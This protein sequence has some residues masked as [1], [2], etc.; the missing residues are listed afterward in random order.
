MN[1]I[2]FPII[3]LFFMHFNPG[4]ANAQSSSS[5]I[6]YTEYIQTYKDIAIRKMNEYKIPASITLAQGLLESGSG[7][8]ALSVEANNHFGIKCHKEW[9]GM[10]YTMDDD[11][12]NECFRKYANPEESYNDHSLFLTTRPRYASLFE[13]DIKDYKGWANGLKNAGYA[14]NPRYADM[15]IKIIEENELYLYDRN[16][17]P[18]AKKDKK[19]KTSEK[20][21]KKGEGINPDISKFKFLEVAEGNRKIYINNNVKLIF[22]REDD[23]PQTIAHDLGIHAFQVLQYNELGKQEELHEGQLIYVEPKKRKASVESHVFRSG[24]TM[25]DVSQLYAIKLKS[26]YKKN[27]IAEGHEPE[28]GTKLFLKKNKP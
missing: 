18:V 21:Q 4:D 26:L 24:E 6:T 11:T 1:R 14:T 15:L 3:A 25:R 8:S 19:E 22:A 20:E 16:M 12:K 27:K 10:T 7:N 23:N 28:S 5:R 13:L 2:A 9:T 17:E